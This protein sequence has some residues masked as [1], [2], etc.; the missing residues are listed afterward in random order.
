MKVIKLFSE[1]FESEKAGGIKL[2]I[3]ID[4]S[5]ILAKFIT[6]PALDEAQF[7]SSSKPAVLV[8]SLIAGC[9]GFIWLKMVLKL[10]VALGS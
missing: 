5:L 4:I 6:L 8:S 7:I 1:F 2:I 3:C 9:I 10:P